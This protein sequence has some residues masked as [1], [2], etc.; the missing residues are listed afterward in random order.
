MYKYILASLCIA[1][2]AG[3]GKKEEPVTIQVGNEETYKDNVLHFEI[4][5]PGNWPKSIELGKRII[6]YSSDA[7]SYRFIP[8]FAEGEK[9]AMIETGATRGD[10]SAMSKAINDFKTE[11]NFATFASDETT[12]LAG[13]PATKLSYTIQSG[14][15]LIH[16][17]RTYTLSDSFYTYLTFAWFDGSQAGAKPAFDQAVNSFKLA[18]VMS[19]AAAAA[20]AQEASSTTERANN[21]FFTMDYPDNFSVHNGISK[22]MLFT[23]IFR[24]DRN[25]CSIQIDV[26]DAQKLTL[27]KVFDQNKGKYANSGASTDMQLNGNPAKYLNYSPVRDVTSRV[28]FIVKNGKVYRIIL[29]WYKPMQ[30][31]F[32]P[33]FERC[34]GTL[35]IK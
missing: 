34:I 4:Q 29:N 35:N 18:H 13:S 6:F 14:N 3:C 19:A 31:N 27:D 23:S 22:G 12:T 25:D 15:D 16:A 32:L 9:G 5:Y 2:L 8:P 20:A 17:T 21:E 26:F 7:A 33:V 1:F 30:D 10:Q 11:Y 24:G 28:Y